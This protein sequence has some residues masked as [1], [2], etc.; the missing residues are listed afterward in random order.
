LPPCHLRT[1]AHCN[2]LSHN[3]SFEYPQSPADVDWSFFYPNVPNPVVRF[4]DVGC[5]YGGLTGAT[6]TPR[7][8]LATCAWSNIESAFVFSCLLAAAL[9]NLYP[10]KCVLALEIRARVCLYMSGHGTPPHFGSKEALQ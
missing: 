3:D 1:R 8:R 6:F 4:L 10:D 9:C 5:G 7:A 2:P